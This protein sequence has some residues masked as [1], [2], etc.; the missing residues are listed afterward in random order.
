[1]ILEWAIL[2][3]GRFCSLGDFTFWVILEWAILEWA[4]L[5]WA[6]LEWAILEW[7]ILHAFN[8]FKSQP[9]QVYRPTEWTLPKDLLGH[10]TKKQ[11]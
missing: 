8:S 3:F 5:K 10:E 11:Q 1:M 4:I 2:Q 7:A 9:G 6:I